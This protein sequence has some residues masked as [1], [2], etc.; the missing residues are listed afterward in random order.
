MF[1][2]HH[3]RKNCN[4]VTFWIRCS[5]LCASTIGN[6]R[7]MWRLNWGYVPDAGKEH[8][9]ER[10]SN[11]ILRGW[12]IS[13]V[14]GEEERVTLWWRNESLRELILSLIRNCA[15]PIARLFSDILA[16]VFFSDNQI[17]DS[18]IRDFV[19]V[20]SNSVHFSPDELN[21]ESEK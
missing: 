2:T 10:E 7:I 13:G 20:V 21:Y 8:K 12:M 6:K 1:M 11:N 3:M 14:K 18:Y 15:S 19:L 17:I 5:H 9:Y 16:A 4:V